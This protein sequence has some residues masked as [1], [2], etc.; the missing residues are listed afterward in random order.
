MRFKD[1]TGRS[2]PTARHAD[3]PMPD[4]SAAIRCS[5]GKR[6]RLRWAMF[7]NELFETLA[8]WNTTLEHRKSPISGAPMSREI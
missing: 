8:E 6:A 4:M 5:T 2:M 3:I 7:S 1:A